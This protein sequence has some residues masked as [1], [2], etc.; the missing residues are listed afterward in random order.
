M[1]ETREVDVHWTVQNG[2]RWSASL[3]EKDAW[4]SLK[5]LAAYEDAPLGWT[6]E[7]TREIVPVAK[8]ETVKGGG[9][10]VAL[11]DDNASVASRQFY[12]AVHVFW[13]CPLCGDTHNGGLYDDPVNQRSPAPNP[14]LWFCER[15]EG[16][17]V[18]HW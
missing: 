13:K 7:R 4:D 12:E 8:G 5:T 6:V 14:S 16:I 1:N 3:S 9:E 2:Q 15:G 18:V 11:D 10:I 17:V